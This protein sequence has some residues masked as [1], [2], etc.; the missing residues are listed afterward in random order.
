[1]SSADPEVPAP[2]DAPFIWVG[3]GRPTLPVLISVP[4]AGRI[5]P[6]AL[7]KAARVP[8]SR[9]EQLEDR[10]ADALI[11]RAVEAGARAIVATRA[12]AWIDLNRAE[13]D[14][15]GEMIEPRPMPPR[16]ESVKVM[17]GLGLIPRRIAGTGEIWRGP[18]GAQQLARRIA[19]DHR[20][21]HSA[22]G[23]ALRRVRARFGVAVLID[24]HSMPGLG[25]GDPVR[26]VVGDR[27][28]QSAGRPIVEAA[29]AAAA[30]TGLRCARNAPY[31]GGYVLE[32]HGRPD[33][34]IHAIQLEF[35]RA[36]Y[37]DA[38]QRAPGSRVGAIRELL[39][40]IVRAVADIAPPP[41]AV[42]AE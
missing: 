8:L 38:A 30:A 40:G 32:R 27:H 11:A 35:D 4:H 41:L 31:A 19:D 28:G 6:E 5:Y 10:H 18:L 39:A 20:P 42:A 16:A 3:E 1:M 21:Y 24:C 26:I 37:L 29:L 25:G 13:T 14:I 9:L 7:C 36:L 22:L 17:G 33:E 15:D 34:N 2:S 23:I 12:R